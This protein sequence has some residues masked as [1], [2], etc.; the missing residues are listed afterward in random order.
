MKIVNEFILKSLYWKYEEL[1]LIALLRK[2]SL[3]TDLRAG[4]S[5]NDPQAQEA[6]KRHRQQHPRRKQETH[7]SQPTPQP[8][9]ATTLTA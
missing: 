3:I 7:R 4:L 5:L 8:T 1:F 2:K 9:T 6:L